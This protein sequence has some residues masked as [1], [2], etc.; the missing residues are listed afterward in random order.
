MFL[1][2]WL[3]SHLLRHFPHSP[4]GFFIPQITLCL[5]CLLELLLGVTL[6]C[7]SYNL[8]V[9]ENSACSLKLLF[10]PRDTLIL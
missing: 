3:I 9:S 7:L 2:F 5:K 4:L 8:H 1:D 10:P 6:L